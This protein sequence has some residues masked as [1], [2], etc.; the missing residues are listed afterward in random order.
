MVQITDPTSLDNWTVY[1]NKPTTPTAEKQQ[2]A[3]CCQDRVKMT[4]NMQKHQPGLQ[5]PAG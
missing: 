3:S 1:F 4:E 5:Q 2:T